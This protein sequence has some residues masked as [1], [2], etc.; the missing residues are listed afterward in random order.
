[1]PFDYSGLRTTADTLITDF[2]RSVVLRRRSEEAADPARPWGAPSSTASDIQA[3]ETI[4]VFLDT[5]R[6]AFDAVTTGAGLGVTN[7]EEKTTRCLVI[8]E[9]SLPEEMGRDWQVDDGTRRYEVLSSR[10]VRP[11]GTL[12][13]YD[14]ELK[15]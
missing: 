14:L 8:A 3:I 13:Y 12:L 10:P 15:L 9:N 7:V 4:G 6:E 2:G 5:V 11:G 1:M